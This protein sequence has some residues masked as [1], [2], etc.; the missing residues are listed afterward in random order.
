MFGAGSQRG[1]DWGRHSR[2]HSL[3]GRKIAVRGNREP[4]LDHID[5]QLIELACQPYL[6]LH[7]HAAARG[8]LAIAQSRVETRDS[9]ALHHKLPW[10]IPLIVGESRMKE[11][12]IILSRR[13]RFA[14]IISI[15]ND[16][17]S[18]INS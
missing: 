18:I 4:C 12:L 14:N 1:K 13:L 2:S 9:R 17:N 7:V 10:V 16:L 8:L 5:A 15:S 3:Y 6:L 11:K